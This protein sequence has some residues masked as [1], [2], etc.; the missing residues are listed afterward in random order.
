MDEKPP[1]LAKVVTMDST[2]TRASP[3]LVQYQT[4]PPSTI[5]SS[6]WE[7]GGCRKAAAVGAGCVGSRRLRTVLSLSMF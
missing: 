5:L 2:I 7:P 6:Q 3:E 4:R 1:P